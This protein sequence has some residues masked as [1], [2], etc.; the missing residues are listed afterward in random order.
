MPDWRYTCWFKFNGDAVQV[1]KNKV[2][3]R[4]LYTHAG[5]TGR[6]LDFPGENRNLINDARYAD[7]VRQLHQ[8]VLD[9]IQL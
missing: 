8:K 4:E 6:W 2:L 3:G 9:Y 5:D 1:E 7:V